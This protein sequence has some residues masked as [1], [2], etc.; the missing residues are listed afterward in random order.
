MRNETLTD[1]YGK[2]TATPFERDLV[3]PLNSLRRF[4]FRQKEAVV[5]VK[6]DRMSHEFTHIPGIAEDVT[7]IMLNIKTLL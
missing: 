2:F 6:I 4:Y 1:T 5:S 3:I 7:D